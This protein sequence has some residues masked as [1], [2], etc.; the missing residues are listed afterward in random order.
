MLVLICNHPPRRVQKWF[1][2]VQDGSEMVQCVVQNGL[3]LFSVVQNGL[4]MVTCGSGW[5]ING[6]EKDPDVSEWS[7]VSQN[8][9]GWLSNGSTC[10]RIV[11]YGS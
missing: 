10:L 2:M 5:F 3:E 7:K 1:R 9:S 4:E 11:Q 8:V 6:S